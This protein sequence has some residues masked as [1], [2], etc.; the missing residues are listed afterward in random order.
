MALRLYRY[1]APGSL[2]L[3]GEHAVLHGYPALVGAVDQTITVELK[4]DQQSACCQIDS[5][6]GQAVYTLAK[7]IKIEPPFQYLLAIIQHYQNQIQ[8][9]FTLKI[10]SQFSSTVGLGSSSAVT[11]A[12]LACMHQWLG[13]SCQLVDLFRIARQLVRAQQ[14]QASGADIAASLLGGVVLFRG[15]L[16]QSER[17][18]VPLPNM[19]VVYSGS[20]MKTADVIRYVNANVEQQRQ[21]YQDWFMQIGNITEQAAEALCHQNWQGF[22]QCLVANQKILC[23]MS[24]NNVAIDSI[25]RTLTGQP[26]ILACKI[27]GSGLGDCVIGLCQP[28]IRP[29]INLSATQQDQGMVQI[30]VNLSQK[31]LQR[32]DY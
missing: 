25:V 1:A 31:G 2:M 29:V 7:P 24:L 5:H 9:G 14:G 11:V 16:N 19:V 15:D 8:H 26:G 13:L 32:L 12:A 3:F 20:K 21:C 28:G 18:N 17:M 27:S 10:T 23:Q 22:A 4:P 30:G 6:L